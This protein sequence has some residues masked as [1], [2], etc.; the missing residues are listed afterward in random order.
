MAK[1]PVK[2][3][4]QLIRTQEDQI[5]HFAKVIKRINE[6]DENLPEWIS[7]KPAAY[8]EGLLH[9]CYNLIENLQM[10]YNAYNGFRE[11][12]ELGYRVYFIR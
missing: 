1:L 12:Q 7:A 6:Q 3:R 10:A 2:V 9:G 4:E 5:P 8:Y 11:D